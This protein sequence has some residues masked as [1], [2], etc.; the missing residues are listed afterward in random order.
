MSCT[1]RLLFLASIVAMTVACGARDG[2]APPPPSSTP[3]P[4]AVAEIT[5]EPTGPAIQWQ[6]EWAPGAVFY[7]VF[8]RSFQ[9]SDGDGIG[10]LA[11]VIERLDYLNDGDPATDSDLGIDGI[12]L[13]PVFESPSYHG[14]DVIDYESIDRDY[15]SNGDFTRLCD[16]ARR[17]G[18]RVIIDF[19]V[20][21]TGAGHPWFTASAKGDA[22]YRDW[23]VWRQGNP[24]W[25]RPWGNGDATWHNSP[26]PT[27]DFYYGIFWGGMPDLNFR[28]REVRDT[29]KRLGSL[30]LARG[31]DGYRLDATRYL[32]ANGDGNGQADQ[33]E[34]HA[35]LRE[36]SAHIRG[37]KPG[38]LLVGE[39]WTTTANIAPYYGSTA[40]V[41]GGDELPASFNFPL[42]DAIVSAAQ[43]GNAK[44]ILDVL[45]EMKRLYPEG[46]LDAPFLRNHDQIRLATELGNDPGK[47]R[48]A[49]AI[50]LTMPGMPFVYYGEEIGLQNGGTG[51][52]DELKR[53]PMPWTGAPGGGFSTAAPWY[54][55]APGQAH[56]N[57][58]AQTGDPDSLLRHYRDLIRMRKRS[59]AMREGA[60]EPIPLTSPGALAFIR[61]GP[62]QRVLVV[63]NLEPGEQRIGP[64]AVS[65]DESKPL[66]KPRVR[67]DDQSS[68]ARGPRVWLTVP[69]HGSAV[70]EL[71]Q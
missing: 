12:W 2:A 11:G 20:N 38:A 35:Y 1:R 70:F 7:Q 49:A 8:V 55:F 22:R 60:I 27:Q 31:A 6:H 69:G 37:E 39:N 33:P 68:P 23:Y 58:A 14:Y 25:R 71:A 42:A 13:M 56:T 10:D 15:G 3:S 18:I 44:A 21:H 61:K 47:L 46:V 29:I 26:E 19:V 9:D 63:H 43:N 16:E 24:G 57:V 62:S 50:L 5:V 52:A 54:P 67:L 59:E 32:I 17:R 36:F 64:L 30:W 41:R 28:N 48:L 53:T 45:A 66:G 51:S 65:I 4:A 34:T 40:R